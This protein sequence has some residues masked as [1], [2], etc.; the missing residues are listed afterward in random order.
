MGI[1]NI[2][3][4]PFWMAGTWI[5]NHWNDTERGQQIEVSRYE[6]TSHKLPES[7]DGF[8]I[9]QIS[10]LHGKAYKDPKAVFHQVLRLHPDVVVVT[11][12]MFDRTID[13]ENIDR[14][15]RIF[16][17]LCSRFP[18]YAILGNH[19]KRDDRCELLAERMRQCGVRLLRNQAAILSVEDA[20]IGICGLE[21]DAMKQFQAEEDPDDLRKRLKLTMD[22]YEREPVD[23]TILLAHKPDHLS[24][25]AEAGADLAFSGHAHGGLMRVPFTEDR[26]LMAPGQGFFPKYTQG[27]YLEKPTMMV[28]SA[29]VGGVRWYI[30]PEIVQVTLRSAA[31]ADPMC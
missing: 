15:I 19:E 28:L 31:A 7:F 14:V 1:H 10:D 23:F 27:L 13:P 2:L 18:V 8:S 16:Q 11:G 9:V 29:G 24:L 30:Q 21:T 5:L 20:K 12:D 17:D 3:F 22:R 25:Y 26:R 6:L 4:R